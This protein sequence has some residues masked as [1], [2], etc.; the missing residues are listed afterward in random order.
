VVIFKNLN[1]LDQ[2]PPTKEK[3]DNCQ[4]LGHVALRGRF[5][6]EEPSDGRN[7]LKMA[8]GKGREVGVASTKKIITPV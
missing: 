4:R 2:S 7:T 6:G 5:E 8:G 3:D 1:R